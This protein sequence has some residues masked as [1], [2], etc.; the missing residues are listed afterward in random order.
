MKRSPKLRSIPLRSK[1]PTILQIIPELETG[2]A[3]LSTIEIVGAISQSGGRALVASEGGRMASRIEAAGGEFIPFAAASKN[4]LR[5]LL[6]AR[7]L[8][9]IIEQDSIDIVHARSRAP[10]WSGY[11]AAKNTKARFM[12]T[13]HG[14]YSEKTALKKR[15]NKVMASGQITIANSKYT[16]NLVRARYGTQERNLRIVYRGLDGSQFNPNA[17]T[18]DR[19]HALRTAWQVDPTHRIVLLAARLS[20]IKG[21]NVVIAAIE[22]LKK[23]DQLDNTKIIFAGSSQ[24]RESYVQQLEAQISAAEL[25][26]KI[27][28]VGHVDDI[29]AALSL[30]H[31]VLVAST[32]PETFGRTAIEAQAMGCPVIA[33]NIGALPETVLAE[34]AVR[35]D[36]RTGWLVPPNNPD[37]LAQA[38]EDSLAM[39][40]PDRASMGARARQHV[41]ENFS[42]D[43][44]RRAT[45]EIYD[46]ILGC[47]LA[48][49]W[50]RQQSSAN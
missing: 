19:R 46:E 37:A 31:T 48:K 13:Y 32:K 14:A 22:N 11:L 35:P 15:Y 43:K 10:A 16:A 18:E 5:I 38:L 50:D 17:I 25:T 20:P 42:L 7:W 49:T 36:Q 3:E 33:T 28:M 39:T 2:G 8:R 21:Q 29:P 4:P 30:T 26:D 44:M 34:P 6:N 40:A 41:L 1:R 12:T 9:H 45:L 47:E 23:R 27:T 24:G